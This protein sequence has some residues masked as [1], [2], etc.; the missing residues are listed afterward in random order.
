MPTGDRS[1]DPCPASEASLDRLRRAGWSV[2]EYTVWFVSPPAMVHLVAGE[3]GAA[4][5][6]AAGPTRGEAARRACLQGE[7]IE[8]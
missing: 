3:A 5:L 1:W 8:W 2:A 6:L 7:A 4:R